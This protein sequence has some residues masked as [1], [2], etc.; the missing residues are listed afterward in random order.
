MR[1]ALAKH[2]GTQTNSLPAST[3]PPARYS[4]CVRVLLLLAIVCVLLICARLAVPAELT[5]AHVGSQSAEHVAHGHA[6][7]CPVTTPLIDSAGESEWQSDGAHVQFGAAI[8][9]FILERRKGAMR[10]RV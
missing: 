5:S 9:F 3:A 10:A 7:H 8:R 6:P 2:A 1:A 4:L